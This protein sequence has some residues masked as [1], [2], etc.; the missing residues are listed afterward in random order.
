M[1][2]THT[3][4]LFHVVFSTKE[5][6]PLLDAK[7]KPRLF[8]YMGGVIRELG[9]TALLINGP[10]DHVHL[11]I[12]LLAKLGLSEAIGKLKANTSGW[13]HREFPERWSFA[14]QSG[15]AGFTVSHSQKQSVL[16][17]I[18]NQEEHHRNISFQEE[19]LMFLQKH[20]IQYD[21]KYLWE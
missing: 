14:W 6:L 11:L 16:D 19:F 21:E 2:H 7:L 15:F 13:V 4:L 17:Y 10:S 18:A 3:N 20:Q 1:A 5:R 8:A 12:L 9:G